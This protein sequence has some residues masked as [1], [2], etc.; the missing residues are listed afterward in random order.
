VL[1]P[2]EARLDGEVIALGGPQQQ[3]LLGALLAE[4]GRVVA[5][6]RLV[7]IIWPDEPPGRARRTAM[8]YVSRLRQSLGDGCV[9]S[10]DRGYRIAT[11]SDALD[12]VRFERLLDEARAAPS[13]E[14]INLIDRALALW[15]GRA[16]GEF[17]DEW[18]ALPHATRLEELRIVAIELRAEAL[19]AAGEYEQAVGELEARVVTYPLRE[20]FVAMLMRAYDAS[21]REAEALRVLARYRDYLVEE[22]GLEPSEALHALEVSILTRDR[23]SRDIGVRSRG[24][25]L[26][27]RLGGGAFGSVYRAIQPGVGREVAVKVIRAELADDPAFVRRFEAEAQLVANL[28]HPHIVPLH[29]FWREPGGAYLVFRLLRGGSAEQLLAHEGA[30][31]LDRVNRLV[32]EIGGALASAHAAGV[33]HRDVRPANVLFDEQGN[34]YLADFGV[35]VD[36]ATTDVVSEQLFNPSTASPYAPPEESRLVAPSPLGDQY[37][38]AAMVWQLL[39]NRSPFE[40]ATAST[41]FPTEL[42]R[43]LPSAHAFRRDV[44][45]ELDA[46]LLRA[47]TPNPDARYDS[48]T[49]L[50][51]AWKGAVQAAASTTG[52]LSAHSTP[53]RREPRAN[54]APEDTAVANPYKGLRP[55]GES[56]ARHFHGRDAAASELA[57]RMRRE[58]LVA[59]VG[60]SGC[61]KSSLL[62][63]G[64]I[65]RLRAAACRV[66]TMLP[67]GDPISQLHNALLAVSV[68]ELDASR[69]ATMLHTVAAQ[70]VEPLI[71]VIDQFEELWT[72]TPDDDRDSFLND[73]A[74]VTYDAPAARLHVV[75]SV[76]A[77]FFDRPLA[78][79][80]LGALVA[81]QT[82]AVTPMTVGELREAVVAPAADA[83]VVFERGLE[84]SLAAEVGEQPASLPMLQFTL[85]DLFARRSG[86][87]ITHDAYE[88]IG[89]IAGAIATRAEELYASLDSAAQEASRRLLCRLV[90]AGDGVDDTRRRVRHSDLPP[91]TAPLTA[92]LEAARLLVADHDPITR[93]PTV[94]I[95]HESLLRAWPRLRRWLTDDHDAIRQLEHIRA[96]AIAWQATDRPDSELYR[97]NRLDA[98]AELLDAR[99]E[100]LTPLEHDFIDASRA[101]ARAVHEREQRTRRR[102]RRGL[103]FT[104]IA[105]VVAL[106]AGSIAIA[107]RNR[108]NNDAVRARTAADV[109]NAARLT[110]DARSVAAEAR[111]LPPDQLDLAL[112]LAVESRHL[113]PSDTTDGALEAVLA[114]ITP[115]LDRIVQLGASITCGVPVSRDGSYAAASTSD[116]VVHLIDLRTGRSRALPNPTGARQCAQ[117]FSDDDRHLVSAQPQGGQVVV[118]DTA[119]G[120]VIG[121]AIKTGPWLVAGHETRPGRV[122]TSNNDP[123]GTVMVWDTTDPHHP[124]RVSRFTMAS[125]TDTFLRAIALADASHPDLLAIGDSDETQ[126]WRIAS[127][128]L[129]YPP[130]P[131][132]ADGES[133]DGATLVTATATQYHFW[134][135]GTGKERSAPLAGITPV[136]GSFQNPVSFSADG[137]RIA[138]KDAPTNTV[139]VVDLAQRRELL[140]IPL[141][142]TQSSPGPFLNDG[143]L[144]VFDGQAMS[145]WR[146]GATAPTPFAT[147]L[148][149]ATGFVWPAFDPLG[150]RVV[151][152]TSQGIDVWDPMTGR[153]VAPPPGGPYNAT[154]Q[155]A[156]SSDGNLLAGRSRSDPVALFDAASRQQIGAVPVRGSGIGVAWSPSG[157]TLA[158]A[159]GT[160]D[161]ALWNLTDPARPKRIAAMTAPEF[162]A[163]VFAVV[164]FSPDGRTL[165]VDGQQVGGG[166]SPLALFAVPSGR[167]LHLLRADTGGLGLAQAAYSPDS[168]TIATVVIDLG[169]GRVLFWDTTTGR[170]RATL[171]LP[172]TGFGVAYVDGGRW[173]A[174][175]AVDLASRGAA[176]LDLW[177]TTTLLSVGAPMLARGDAAILAADRSGGFRLASGSTSDLGRPIVWDLDPSHWEAMAC[178][179][180]GRNL[181]RAEWRQYVP[182]RPYAATC[183][184]WP[185][186]SS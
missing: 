54:A 72:L 1:G 153:R 50:L 173:L 152:A 109:A 33:V 137:E 169:P 26:G 76:R 82:V 6:E 98:A 113:Q 161:V 114:G 162:P 105:L 19:I 181:T 44:P 107:Q 12:A 68:H 29:D 103:V 138:V 41:S 154:A 102:L 129:A 89:G 2:I 167:L 171:L 170:V 85:A 3:R 20:R 139:R 31:S 69:V 117:A 32:N 15:R 175:G 64:V 73:L 61:G 23:A 112:L 67:G 116:G 185:P 45:R 57:E 93:E 127:H 94:E 37:R 126:V 16:F 7:E 106:V 164:Q 48:M 101:S 104:A 144:S 47:T 52:V 146:I 28:E 86:R 84:H 168:R 157:R 119:T 172:Y 132:I 163:G 149:P 136:S 80:A 49:T 182:G 142:G 36:D 180:A 124:R 184:Q 21:G 151:A 150:R 22:T 51:G 25:L 123:A 100:Q 133:P 56:D 75:L 159:T 60:P 115:G 156:Y 174:T 40:G 65:P 178:R 92:M 141:G 53:A 183:P 99:P 110:S 145:L 13:T 4:G 130:L 83:G 108:A 39:T 87:V 9:L 143:R 43:P 97:G 155:P 59:L 66:V 160:G 118:W 14:A 147:T 176:R 186:A 63:A 74:V 125:P 71:V 135:V 177:N 18:W 46:V 38:F 34:A 70:A 131:G 111:A 79:G 121:A 77:D 90:V 91:G 8:S 166:S 35:A 58:R 17:A 88:A 120:R 179:L 134:D 96:T 11:S 27:E 140:S 10:Q 81:S 62:H 128:T 165:A 24:Y 30:L 5:T 148:G 158:T 78:H 95:A 122:V 42:E 55:F